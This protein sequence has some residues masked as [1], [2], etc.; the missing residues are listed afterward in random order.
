MK[1]FENL[2]TKALDSRVRGND[3]RG[4]L[5]TTYPLLLTVFER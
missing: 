5:L 2:R 4:E 3:I 1:L